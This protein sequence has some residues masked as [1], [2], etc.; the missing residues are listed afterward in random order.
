M[1]IRT[2][3]LFTTAITSLGW[4]MAAAAQNQISDPKPQSDTARSTADRVT[5]RL[6]KQGKSDAE[7]DIVVVGTRKPIANAVR[8]RRASS[9]QVD[10]GPAEA[11][12]R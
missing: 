10:V 11:G 3:A 9:A 7:G 1:S 8:T 4:S 12:P 6:E 5:E 2:L